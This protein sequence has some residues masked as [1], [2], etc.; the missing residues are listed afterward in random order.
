MS[1]H[2]AVTGLRPHTKSFS[3]EQRET[4]GLA[5]TRA[6]EAAGWSRPAFSRISRVGKTSLYKLETGIPVG[7]SVYEAA[8]RALPGWNE[9]T[10]LGILA[11]EL[12]P[13]NSPAEEEVPT[14]AS[15]LDLE[16]R[17]WPAD[18][19]V[20]YQYLSD[21]L[22]PLGLKLTPRNYLIMKDQAENDF[23][24]ERQATLSADDRQ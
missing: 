7:P 3:Q 18:E 2:V 11:G 6:R 20:K 1:H 5:F 23:E 24:R 17:M 15:D 14:P 4:L 8:A 9:D 12:A 10:P 16:I 21:M 13:S 19:Q 22:A